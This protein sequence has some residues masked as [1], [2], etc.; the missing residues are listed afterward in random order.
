MEQEY[1]LGVDPGKDGAFVVLNQDFKIV[2]AIITP[3]IGSKRNYDKQAIRDIFTKYEYKLVVIEKPSNMYGYS[4]S[5]AES[6]AHCIGLFEGMVFALG[7]RH[8]LVP[9]TKWQP[10]A[11]GDTPRQYKAKDENGKQK[12]DPKATSELAVINFHPEFEFR[13]VGARGQLLKNRHDGIIDGA[14][15][16]RYGI[17]TN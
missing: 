17:L 4:K 15:V 9:P 12:S 3:T 2:E 5:A 10:V 14:L 1:Y 7:L 11:W 13:P 16:A 8:T 6:I